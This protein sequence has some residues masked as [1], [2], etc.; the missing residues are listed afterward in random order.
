LGVFGRLARG[1]SITAAQGELDALAASLAAGHSITNGGVAIRAVPIND[2]FNGRLTDTVWLAFLTAGHLVLLVACANVANLLLMRGF[3]RRRELAIRAAI[4]AS[5]LRLLRQ[6]L[7][8]SAALAAVAGG[9]GLV[10]SIGA[11]TLLDSSVPAALPLPYWIDFS[12]DWRVLAYAILVCLTAVVLSG[13][14]PALHTSGAR[15][16]EALAGRQ[17]GSEGRR[18]QRWTAGLLAVQFALALVLLSNIAVAVRQSWRIQRT[19]MPIETSRLLTARLTLPRDAY[20]DEEARSRFYSDLSERLAPVEHVASIALTTHLPFSGGTPRPLAIAGQPAMPGQPAPTVLAV[21]V[22]PSYFDALDLPAVS[23]RTFGALDGAQGHEAIVINER[24]A[25]LFLPN[26]QTIGQHVQ[27]GTPGNTQE[28]PWLPIVGVVPNVRQRRLPLPDPVAYVPLRAD[29][30]GSV[31]VIVRSSSAV[32]ET[33]TP[34]LRA[35]VR[36]LDPE[37]PLDRALPMEQALRESGWNARV[38]ARILFSISAISFVLGLVGLYGLT[39]YGVAQRS[40]EIGIRVALGAKPGDMAWMVIRRVAFQVGGGLAL[41]FLFTLAFHAAFS[42]V[43]APERP[44]D[45]ATF[46]PLVAIV[47]LVSLAACAAPILRAA[48]VDP[49]VTLRMD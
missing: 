45:P 47:T 22:T 49:A 26:D 34:A 18:A 38:S 4:G 19:E 12:V 9:I 5:R 42:A 14:V 32:P 15:G 1:T 43:E 46:L 41:G 21:A 3:G 24:L 39:S 44:T 25:E 10:L 30:P 28:G 13:L 31:A 20:P 33:L 8:E 23:G 48:R 40:R 35:I 2:Q 7:F 27:L 11:V 6:L 16:D 17:L 29:P 36:R 37:L